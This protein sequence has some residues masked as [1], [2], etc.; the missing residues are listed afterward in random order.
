MPITSENIVNCPKCGQAMDVT[1]LPPYSRAACP[2]CGETVRVKTRMGAYRL[3]G[4]LGKGG[5][6]VVFRAQDAVLGREVALKVLSES[7]SDDAVR[8]DRFEKEARIMAR[9]SHENLVKVYS[10][11][12]DHGLFYIAM[13]LVEGQGL[14]E[15]IAQLG[16][17]PEDK[18][19]ALMQ[20][21]V[22]G[23]EAAH[24]A[25]LLHRDIKPANILQAV[26]GTAK[27]VDF[28]LSLL[29][30]EEDTEK[31]IW[32]T[33][34]YAAPETLLRTGEDF[35]TDMYALGATMYH[36]L[37]GAPPPVD[38]GHSTDLLLESKKKL[39][40]LA[41]VAPDISPFSC[42]IVDKLMS[43][44]LEGRF[45][46]YAELMDA[47]QHAIDKNGEFSDNAPNKDWSA[48]RRLSARKRRRSK[49]M[50]VVYMVLTLMAVILAVA[51]FLSIRYWGQ[52]DEEATDVV[53]AAPVTEVLKPPTP[54]EY[55]ENETPMERAERY[56]RL[57]EAAMAA[58]KEKNVRKAEGLFRDLTEQAACPLSTAMWAGL[59]RVLCLWNVGQFPDGLTRL[60]EL[61]QR[62]ASCADK[63]EVERA[64]NVGEVI[65][66]LNDA[67]VYAVPDSV[68]NPELR[69]LAHVGL[70]L[71]CWS[72]GG[73][74]T[75][76]K[77]LHQEV[78]MVAQDAAD[79]ELSL[80]AAIWIENLE[81]Y[82]EQFG[83][84]MKVYELP[85][86]THA[87]WIAKKKA[88]EALRAAMLNGDVPAEY[89]S[90]AAVEGILSHLLMQE[91]EVRMYEKEEKE[92]KEK[93]L[94][95][96]EADK[97][98]EEKLKAQREKEKLARQQRTYKDVCQ[99]M[100]ERFTESGDY[101]EIIDFLK[102]T[103]DELSVADE[104]YKVKV[105][106][107]MTEAM[108]PL[109]EGMKKTLPDVLTRKKNL[110]LTL[111]NG[112]KALL[113]GI[114]D[115]RLSVE[116][117]KERESALIGWEQMDFKSMRSLSM[118]CRRLQPEVFKPLNKNYNEPLLIFAKLTNSMSAEQE[119]KVLEKMDEEFIEMWQLW[120][121]F[122]E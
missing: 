30:S 61:S 48:Y 86:K 122:Y 32:V 66:L 102:K 84:L 60:N 59:N 34:Y 56:G 31:E 104:K 77:S 50:G 89:T 52:D 105:R 121:D 93:E 57:Y 54:E 76:Y 107:E 20:D 88:A 120:M 106:R 12:H 83:I 35:R 91:E 82:T 67:T 118:E 47:L 26:D 23:L 75:S 117:G 58:I 25:G 92:R 3:T 78:E 115:G 8:C 51:V 55:M 103:E 46:S 96:T 13:E 81:V 53:A 72:V 68:T 17:V 14:D 16:R 44:E 97:K 36:M 43:Y 112:D 114:K 49:N 108:L 18:T 99:E 63:A 7:W 101:E 62:L 87:E 9:V 27:I 98:K 69:L 33:P 5:M 71:K 73:K 80:L 64:K 95:A 94:A 90:F 37:V 6:S 111:K 38:T 4:R 74:W 40:S 24:Q 110:V 65:V 100:E 119:S 113:T 42:F 70:A 41:Q 2:S 85:E 19:L 10:V 22:R 79:S 116:K 109:I 21:V 39:P 45:S 11:G 15:L 1:V 29:N 28:G